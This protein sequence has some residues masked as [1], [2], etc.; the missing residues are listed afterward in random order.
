MRGVWHEDGKDVRTLYLATAKRME[1]LSELEL[2]GS[3]DAAT[4]PDRL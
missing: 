2:V 3:T 1:S 4:G